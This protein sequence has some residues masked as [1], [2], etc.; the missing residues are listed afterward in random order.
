MIGF[1]LFEM[2]EVKDELNWLKYVGEEMNLN[3]MYDV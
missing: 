2:F 3:K 1:S